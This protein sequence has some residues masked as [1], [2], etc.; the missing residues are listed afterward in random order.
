M[1]K[2][3]KSASLSK[4]SKPKGS[5]VGRRMIKGLEMALAH[6]RGEIELPGYTV[7][8]TKHKT[9]RGQREGQPPPHA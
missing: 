8:V 5:A 1:T 6:R 2:R 7:T 4:R 3:T 9:K